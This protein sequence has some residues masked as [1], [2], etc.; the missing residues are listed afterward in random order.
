MGYTSMTPADNPTP[1]VAFIVKDPEAT[2]AKLKRANVTAKVVHHQL[3]ISPS[4]FNDQ[5][6]IDK[7]L[8]ALA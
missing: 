2:T 5:Q 8:N 3:R 6:D 4:V 1:I 7:L